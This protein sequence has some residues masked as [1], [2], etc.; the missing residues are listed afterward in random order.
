MVL[1]IRTLH[2]KLYSK[3]RRKE[4][5][6]NKGNKTEHESG[7]RDGQEVKK[8]PSKKKIGK[9]K[10]EILEILGRKKINT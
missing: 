6:W 2:E 1:L 9:G 4:S 3:Y 7:R 8:E 10:N 5:E